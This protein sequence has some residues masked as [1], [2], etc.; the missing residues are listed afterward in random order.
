MPKQVQS[1]ESDNEEPVRTEAQTPSKA[2]EED[3][4]D[5][6]DEG[7]SGG[8]MASFMQDHQKRQVQIDQDAEYK[9]SP[10]GYL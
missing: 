5:C 10:C 7:H 1:D 6:S 9:Q 2:T 4:K 8:S 3:K